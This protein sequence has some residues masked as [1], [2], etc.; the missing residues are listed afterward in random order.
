MKT[1]LVLIAL[2]MMS[3][4]TNSIGQPAQTSGMEIPEG[5]KVK[6]EM[7]D[8][9]LQSYWGIGRFV[10]RITKRQW[11]VKFMHNMA[12]KPLAG[13][14]IAE[15]QNEER[16]I[17]SSDGHEIRVRIFKPENS[18]GKLPAMLYMHGGGYFMG[19]PEQPL[20]FYEDILKRR[21]VVI[22]VPAYRL[23]IDHPFPAGFN[24]SYETLLWM[25]ENA[26]E[27]GIY[28]HNF[29]L[30]GHSAGGGM[31]AAVTLKA[32]DTKDVKIAFFMPIYPMIDH[33]QI[34]ES[35]QIR[36][37]LIWDTKTNKHGWEQYLKGLEGDKVPAYASPALNTDYNEFPPAISFVGDLEP[38][39][40]ETFAYIEALKAAGVPTKFKLFKG[41]FHGF[42]NIAPATKIGK[43]GNQ[44][45]LDAFEEYFDKYV[46]VK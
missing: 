14:T 46:L 13:N 45:Q 12:I 21:D 26:D 3:I 35:S 15:V 16:Y 33:R 37:S 23:S 25:K 24:D 17:K 19:I 31:T 8:E 34:T 2:V 36:K 43:E 38:F 11:G 30:A 42:E 29:I 10:A 4:S 28:D 32:R 44:F 20:A 18:S 5:L 27:L 22:V 41:A 39:K 9:E 6:K 7:H 1:K 40:D